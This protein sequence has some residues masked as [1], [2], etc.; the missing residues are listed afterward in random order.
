MDYA[1]LNDKWGTSGHTETVSKQISVQLSEQ[2]VG[3]LTGYGSAIM[4]T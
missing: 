1:T 2:M 3:S 4:E